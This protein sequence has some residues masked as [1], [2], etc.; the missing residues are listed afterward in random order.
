MPLYYKLE[1]SSALQTLS[2]ISAPV[3][4]A[5]KPFWNLSLSA[6]ISEGN[7][8]LAFEKIRT[9]EII[10]NEDIF[11]FKFFNCTLIYQAIFINNNN[12][13]NLFIY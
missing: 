3:P 1:T 12:L 4:I 6:I 7:S 2:L 8:K 5:P 13:I 9:I 11:I 10:S